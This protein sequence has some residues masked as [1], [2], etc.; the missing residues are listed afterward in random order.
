MPVLWKYIL[1]GYLR[2]FSLSVCTFIS[3]LLVSRFKDIARFAALSSDWGKTALF[4]L[5]QIPHILPIAVPIS[6][7]IAAILLFQRLSRTFELTALRASGVSLFSLLSPVILASCFLSLFNFSFCADLAPFCRRESKTLLYR[8]TSVNPLL[9]LQRQ[10]LVKLK[11]AYMNME[12]K[13][14]GRVAE[15]F[16]LIAH[17]ESNQRLNFLS[18]SQLKVEGDALLG[19]SVAIISHLQSDVPENFDPLV[20]ENQTSM[21][22]SAPVIS[23]ALKKNRPPLDANALNLKMLRIRA[24]EGGKKGNA[25]HVEVLRRIT[26]SIAVFSF[27]LLG[28]A[29]GMEQGRV[30]TKKGV[31]TAL[32][33]TL[34][35]LV[36]YL[37]GKELKEMP[38]IATIAF[39]LPHPVIW[40]ASGIQLQRVSKGV[41]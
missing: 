17:N 39:L 8:E 34:T 3:V 38:L 1:Y 19:N 18:A 35:V 32:S 16:L 25:A 23:A 33:F 4:T 24:D 13:E 11:H 29:F 28:C 5:Y 31:I 40:L 26:L 21:A 27:T 15:D 14:E 20:I 7:L 9:L 30:P 41:W 36:S 10:H 12:V 2:V 37:L 22:T 6:A